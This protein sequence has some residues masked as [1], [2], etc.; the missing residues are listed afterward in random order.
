MSVQDV[1]FWL[2][3]AGAVGGLVAGVIDPN[4]LAWPGFIRVKTG[5]S[6]E[7]K[8]LNLGFVGPIIVGAVAA[9]INWAVY[10]PF[11]D[12]AVIAGQSAANAAQGGAAASQGPDYSVTWLMV[13]TSLLIGIFGG[14]WLGAEADKRLFKAT[15]IEASFRTANPGRAFLISK[16]KGGAEALQHARE[17]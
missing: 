3:G 16:S 6:S 9:V 10:G 2:L 5:E 11:A 14:K 12:K 4:G 7:K 1:L 15:A 13:G 8:F 17:M